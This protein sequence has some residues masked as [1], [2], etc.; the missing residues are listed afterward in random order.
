MTDRRGFLSNETLL[1]ITGCFASLARRFANPQVVM[2]WVYSYLNGPL[3][4]VGL[5]VP[6]MRL[7]ALLSQV[8]VVPAMLKV[9]TRKWAYV[10]SAIVTAAVLMLISITLY[11][12]GRTEALVLFFLGLLLMGASN[13]ISTLTMTEV[14][15]KTLPRKRV[16]HVLSVQVSV[17]GVVVLLVMGSLIYFDPDINQGAHKALMMLMAAAAWILAGVAMARVREPPSKV[18]K[19]KSS[20]LAEMA[21]GWG[22]LKKVAWFRRFVV[23]RSIFLF[24][25]LATPFYSIHAAT[26]F[27]K[28]AHSLSLIVI[29]TGITS[30]FS[31]PVWSGLLQRDPRRAFFRAGMLAA[32]A[33]LIVFVHE[34]LGNPHTVM[35]MIVFSL[36]QLAVQGLTSATKTYL[37]AM[38][39]EDERPRYLAVGN[40]VLGV[41][42][43]IVSGLIGVLADSVHIYAALGLLVVMAIVASATALRLEKPDMEET[44]DNSKVQIQEHSD[45]E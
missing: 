10:I 37:T 9:Q 28:T 26:V 2:P 19:K 18:R 44:G 33:G 5:L 14:V 29:A 42:A 31:V 21:E 35:Y 43:I 22:Y 32:A 7:G 15:A 23:V 36:L 17:S 40:A 8:S 3:F 30:I 1:V 38:S 34:Y 45:A 16:G 20:T 27:T 12:M 11:G 4:L 41:L 6:S 24:V 13:G 25:G 39:P